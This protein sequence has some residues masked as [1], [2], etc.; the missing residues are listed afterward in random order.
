MRALRRLVASVLAALLLLAGPLAVPKGCTE[1]PAGC[2]M[3]ARGA[4]GEGAKKQ[5][6]CHRA[7]NPAPVDGDCLR[8]ACG[9][10]VTVETTMTVFG[11]PARPM[12]VSSPAPGPRMPAPP[13]VVASLDAPEPLLRPPRAA[14]A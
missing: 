2:P 6:G 14:H 13:V 12:R 3:H 11:L 7:T 10:D 4:G 8:S 1:C 9:H 5:P